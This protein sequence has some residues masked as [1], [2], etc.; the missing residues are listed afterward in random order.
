MKDVSCRFCSGP[1]TLVLE[2]P[3][4]DALNGP[5]F[6]LYNCPQCR[7]AFV[8]PVPF[9]EETRVLYSQ[10][11]YSDWNKT[12]GLASRCMIVSKRWRI[13]SL[14]AKGNILDFGCGNGEFLGEMLRAGWHVR[15]VESSDRARSLLPILL[16]DH[17]QK[18]LSDWEGERFDVIT[19]WHVLEHLPEPVAV[20]RRLKG[21][22]KEGGLLFLAVPNLD[23]WEFS[24]CGADW[25]HLDMPRHLVHFSQHG[26]TTMLENEG[27]RVQR[28]D[29][30][31]WS[32]NVFGL[33]QTWL[34]S[35][36]GRRNAFYNYFKRRM[37][38][39]PGAVAASMFCMPFLLL[40]A[41]PACLIAGS[42]G[43]AGTM[44]L[45]ARER[46]ADNP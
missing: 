23:S 35:I 21:L 42:V 34:N 10:T 28:A 2:A 15:G 37:D 6:D 44:E 39:S 3:C 12:L 29:H 33:V 16:K 5:L 14:H 24:F 19:L 11:Y 20:I 46:I 30:F 4:P 22:L 36:T 18:D 25:F 40:A 45:Y 9:A 7:V 31:A 17:V 8:W 1:S 27:L 43:K 41:I 13:E 32:Y 38:S 26:L